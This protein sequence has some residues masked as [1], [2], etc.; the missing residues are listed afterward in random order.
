LDKDLSSNPPR[1]FEGQLVLTNAAG[2]TAYQQDIHFNDL[3]DY[4]KNADE[5]GRHIHEILKK[6]SEPGG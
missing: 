4:A 6:I 5:L 1:R 3:D 2:E